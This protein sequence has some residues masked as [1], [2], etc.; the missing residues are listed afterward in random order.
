[1]VEHPEA[2]SVRAG[3]VPTQRTVQV[4]RSQGTVRLL[5]GW[6]N[7]GNRAGHKRTLQVEQWLGE[8]FLL[9]RAGFPAQIAGLAVIA[10][11][12]SLRVISGEGARNRSSVRP[13]AAFSTKRCARCRQRSTAR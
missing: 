13:V 3:E 12:A 11:L 1:M 5:T 6:E 7:V 8:A 2:R 4:G 9:N 10:E